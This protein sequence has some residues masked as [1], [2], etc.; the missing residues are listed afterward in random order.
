MKPDLYPGKIYILS[1]GCIAPYLPSCVWTVWT[2]RWTTPRRRYRPLSRAG[3][4][5][6]LRE[7]E[8]KFE[9]E[10]G[11]ERERERSIYEIL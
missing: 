1:G 7:R 8:R 9:R 11:G 10:K 3:R 6:S 4:L 5:G 2:G